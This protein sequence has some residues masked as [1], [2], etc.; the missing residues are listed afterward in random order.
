MRDNGSTLIEFLPIFEIFAVSFTTVSLGDVQA[1]GRFLFSG[2][3]T[4]TAL[5]ARC[6][7]PQHR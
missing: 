6:D 2:V 1:S 7:E 3:S 4:R 5:G